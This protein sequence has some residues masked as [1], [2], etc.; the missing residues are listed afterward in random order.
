MDAKLLELSNLLS[1]IEIAKEKSHLQVY[2]L[3]QDHFTFD[4]EA[5]IICSYPMAKIHCDIANDYLEKLGE[6]LE[7][8]RTTIESLIEE[9]ANAQKGGAP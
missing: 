9:S 3:S 4:Q 7:E 8:A 1:E 5:S 6:L 2:D